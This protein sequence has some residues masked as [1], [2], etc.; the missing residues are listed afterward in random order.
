MHK[1]TI[2]SLVQVERP[3]PTQ[4][5]EIDFESVKGGLKSE[6]A[7]GFLHWGAFTNYVYKRRWVGSPEMSCQC[8]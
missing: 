6:S 7:E 1:K 5:V 3:R 2:F 8:L 4:W